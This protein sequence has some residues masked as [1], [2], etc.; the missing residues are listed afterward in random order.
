MHIIEGRKSWFCHRMTK[1]TSLD[2][3]ALLLL[4]FSSFNF[5]LYLIRVHVNI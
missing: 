4:L 5:T 2:C 1:Y 3:L